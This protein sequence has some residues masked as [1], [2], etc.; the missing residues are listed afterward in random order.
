MRA[1]G[2]GI[3]ATCVLQRFAGVLVDLAGLAA[4]KMDYLRTICCALLYNT[5]WHN[6]TPLVAHVEES[7]RAL[8]A[9]LRGRCKQHPDKHT[10]DEVVNLFRTM[11]PRQ[12]ARATETLSESLCVQVQD[13][14]GH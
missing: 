2:S 13:R 12:R 7:C 10:A 3:V 8:L 6:N 9:K 1:D 4:A 14:Y 11:P 5:Q